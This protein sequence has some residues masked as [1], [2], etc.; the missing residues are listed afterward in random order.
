MPKKLRVFFDSSA[1]LAGLKSPTGAAGT[2]LAAC[3]VGEILPV[4]SEQVVEETGRNIVKKFPDAYEQWCSFLILPPELI[5]DISVQ[6]I[7]EAYRIIK[8]NDAPILA[9]AIKARPDV[10]VTWDIK[11]F[12]RVEV[13]NAISAPVLKPEEFLERCRQI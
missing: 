4:V 7:E 10:F 9:A 5:R 12:M 1:L 8:T 2:I 11:H 3:F 6:E 13:K